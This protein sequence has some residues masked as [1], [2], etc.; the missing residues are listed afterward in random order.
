M[1]GKLLASELINY[2]SKEPDTL[3]KQYQTTLST[4][5]NKHA[6]LHTHTRHIPR[7]VNETVIAVKETKYLFE[8]IWQRNKSTFNRAQYIQKVHQYNR[9]CMQAKPQFLKAKI[10]DNHHNPQKLWRDVLHRLPAKLL[11][12]IKPPQICG[13]LHGKKLK[14]YAQH[15]LLSYMFITH[16][17]RFS[18]PYVFHVLCCN[19][20]SSCQNYHQL[21]K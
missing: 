18:S 7:W 2:P 21:S 10:Q 6:P 9:I 1:K 11:Q 8:H 17:H 12:S 19:R 15:S 20:G 13:V 4:L 5:I 3:Y 14:K 16:L